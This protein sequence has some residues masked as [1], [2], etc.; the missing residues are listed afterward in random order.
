MSKIPVI[1]KKC[2]KEFICDTEG[3]EVE[4]FK[5]L[6][7]QMVIIERCTHCG[8]ANRVIVPYSEG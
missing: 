6:S 4:A 7:S 5:S 2:E 3:N 8:H 1:C